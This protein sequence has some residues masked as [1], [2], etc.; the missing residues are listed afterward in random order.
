MSDDIVWWSAERL[1]R[2]YRSGE[3]SPVDAAEAVIERMER[4]EPVI[5]AFF[6]PTIELAR[7]EA[8]AS[9]ERFRRGEP[10]GPMDGVPYSIKDLE[11]TAGIRTTFGS[12]AT[13]D[14]VPDRDG[15]VA[16]RLRASGGVLLGK[17]ATPDGGYKDTSETLIFPAPRNPWDLDRTPGGSSGG[18]AAAVAS[19]VGPLAQ[20]TDGAGSIRIPSALC[21]LVGLKATHGR[22]PVWPQPFYRDSVAHLGPIA[23]TVRDTALMLDVIAGPDRRD[24][25]SVVP[26]P[27]GGFL[28]ALDEA[29]GRLRIGVSIDLGYGVVEPEIAAA[30]EEAARVLGQQHEVIRRDPGWPDPSREQN[31]WWATEFGGALAEELR[32]HPER[33]E[34][35]LRELVE[36]ARDV[37]GDASFAY[38]RMR[39]ALHEAQLA[40]FDDVDVLL[41]PTMPTAAW[42]PGEHPETV[43]GRRLPGGRLGRNFLLFPFNLIGSPAISVPVG[44]TGEGLP[45]GAQL[46]APAYEEVRLLRVAAQLEER[47][48]FV[49]A[50][51]GLDRALAGS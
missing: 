43:A 51:P 45:I 27:P 15:S 26:N 36:S 3:I 9:A 47:I 21:G 16:G 25:W 30:V 39:G 28:A 24:P 50:T 31:D 14:H 18:A 35:Q 5:H 48:G 38:R 22:V 2:A 20:G 6:T 23:R 7:Q 1:S 4:V 17:T 40:L 44:L 11:P 34:P 46:V 49:R 33:F 32:E 19:G 41:T 42:R 12:P 8:R 29:P 10:I 37:E 13:A